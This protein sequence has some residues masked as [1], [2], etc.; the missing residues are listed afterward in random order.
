MPYN[1]HR[2][3][4]WLVGRFCLAWCE[5]SVEYSDADDEMAA[6]EFVQTEE[7]LACLHTHINIRKSVRRTLARKKNQRKRKY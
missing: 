1:I 4:I 2:M 3:K 5:A 7:N 6:L